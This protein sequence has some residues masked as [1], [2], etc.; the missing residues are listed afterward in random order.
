MTEFNSICVDVLSEGIWAVFEELQDPELSR[1]A[2][3]LPRTVMREPGRFDQA[4][5]CVCF[6]DV[7]ELGSEQSRGPSIPNQGG[8]SGLIL[9][10]CQ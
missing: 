4:E 10:A 2:K 7:E 1:L 3:A 5:V 9:T 6:P 8:T